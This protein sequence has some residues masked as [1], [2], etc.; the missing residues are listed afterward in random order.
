MVLSEKSQKSDYAYGKYVTGD[1]DMKCVQNI[2]YC[3]W[4]YRT[5]SA[6]IYAHRKI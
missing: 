5:T 4:T 2:G 1:R 3:T 6:D